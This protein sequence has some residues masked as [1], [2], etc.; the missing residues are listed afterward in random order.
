[1]S[2]SGFY[3]I[4]AV[5]RANYVVATTS[6]VRRRNHLNRPDRPV[7]WLLETTPDSFA[8]RAHSVINGCFRKVLLRRPI[9]ESPCLRRH[10]P[11]LKNS[12]LWKYNWSVV[13]T[14][15]KLFKTGSIDVVKDCQSCFAIDLL[16]CVLERRQDKFILRYI[17]TV[18][19][20]ILQ[21]FVIFN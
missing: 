13:R 2:D 9:I 4:S 21:Q 18:N 19:F 3:F 1:M 12:S 6:V 10:S 20:V 14:P 11:I 8:N 7:A 17:S 5:D 16:S 15:A